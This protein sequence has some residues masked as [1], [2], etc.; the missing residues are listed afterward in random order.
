[1][2]WNPAEAGVPAEAGIIG[3]DSFVPGSGVATYAYA[4]TIAAVAGVAGHPVCAPVVVRGAASGP[5]PFRRLHVSRQH[6]R[7]LEL[8]PPPA[9]VYS[10]AALVAV[11]RPAITATVSYRDR[12]AEIVAEDEEALLLY[13]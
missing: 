7:R 6:F 8:A 10:Y 12:V 13:A 11:S 3:A 5:I 9:Q 2:T 1:M 4:G